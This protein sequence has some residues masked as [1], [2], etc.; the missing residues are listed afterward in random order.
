MLIQEEHVQGIVKRIM[1]MPCRE[2]DVL[3]IA[4]GE[5]CWFDVRQL[6]EELRQTGRRFFG[7][8]FPG[9][10][11]G[12]RKYEKGCVAACL[13]D[14]MNPMI[15]KSISSGSYILPDLTGFS[16]SAAI[17]TAMLFVDGL[18]SNIS[19]LL[20]KLQHGLGPSVRFAG[21]GAGSISLRRFPVVFSREGVFQDAAVLV[22]LASECSLGIRHGWKT[23][24]GPFVANK[25]Q[26]NILHE[27]NYK[28]ALPFYR[29]IIERDAGDRLTA[30][31]FYEL[32]MRYPLGIHVEHQE[33]IVRD[34]LM[35]DSEGHLVCCG[36]ME[37]NTVIS[38][39]KGN[40]VDLI[41]AAEDAAD[42]CLNR[43]HGRT[44]THAFVVDCISRV[45]FL[46]DYFERELDGINRRLA[47]A[48]GGPEPMG[49]LTLGE[50]ASYD[51]EEPRL[52]NKTTVLAV[53]LQS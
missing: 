8:V 12:G 29:Q 22:P 26:G 15:I 32:A 24:A 42:D 20:R 16:G 53:L 13:P 37:E 43:A 41:R 11:W 19:I 38:I 48:A 47:M 40:P 52:F 30:D 5:Q 34:P 6:V 44:V 23:L 21:G 3:F 18:S 4:L 46:G 49:V 36:D 17:R 35:V 31:H 28:D 1:A 7:G 9:V 27:I 51:Q 45:H 33:A 2:T 10:I 25:T 50:I 39:L 14:A